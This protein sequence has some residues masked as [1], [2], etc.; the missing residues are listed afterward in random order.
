MVKKENLRLVSFDHAEMPQLPNSGR[1]WR[2]PSVSPQI[3][4]W[5]VT[6][7]AAAAIAAAVVSMGDPLALFAGTTAVLTGAS[8]PRDGS[9]QETPLVESGA[10]TQALPSIPNDAP[11]DNDVARPSET[12]GQ[13]QT[14]ITQAPTGALLGQFQAWAANRDGLPLIQPLQSAQQD[15]TGSIQGIQSTDPAQDVRPEFLPVP[16][17]RQA[18][19]DKNARGELGPKPNPRAKGRP[20][21]NGQTYLLP[22]QVRETDSPAVQNTRPP[23]FLEGFGIRN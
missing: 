1:A 9:G 22:A 7:V 6:V 23:S 12:A 5:S 19:R 13:R 20:A 16:Q 11:A 18:K 8:T 17:R 3:L 14:E 15:Q 4:K 2:R 21:P 10:S